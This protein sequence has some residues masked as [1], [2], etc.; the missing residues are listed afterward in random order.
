MISSI[1]RIINARGPEDEVEASAPFNEL[2]EYFFL[3]LL[4]LI[5]AL[6]I[7]NRELSVG[8]YPEFQA[9]AAAFFYPMSQV[10][11]APA[12]FSQL[13]ERLEGLHQ[14]LETRI[15]PEG[16]VPEISVPAPE[17]ASSS[18]P[19]KLQGFVTFR[20]VSFPYPGGAPLLNRFSLSLKPG[21][22]ATLAGKSGSGKNTVIKLLQGLCRPSSGEVSID[23]MAPDRISRDLFITQ[24]RLLE[25]IYAIP[26]TK[27]IVAQRLA[28]VRGCDSIVVLNQETVVRQG[29]FSEVIGNASGG[30]GAPVHTKANEPLPKAN[31]VG[32]QRYRHGQRHCGRRICIA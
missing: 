15:P 21:E 5:S 30:A 12:L 4:L 18:A 27:L 11:S 8:S 7:M 13:E 22:R 24:Q 19:D 10:L 2:P 31:A 3:N 28:T 16:G 26:A 23:G 1:I 9:Y 25:Q 14:E 32:N 20:E 17:S 6:R 29:T